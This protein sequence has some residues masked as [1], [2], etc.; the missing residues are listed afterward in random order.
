MKLE[1][2]CNG[3]EITLEVNGDERALDILRDRLGL[4]GTKEGCGKGEC[5]ACTVIVDGRTMN[6]CLL[7][8]AKLHGTRVTTIEGIHGRDGG[9]HPIQVAYLDKGAVQCGFCTPGMVL[10]TKTLLDEEPKPDRTR[11]SEALSGNF[12]RCTGY[13]KIVEAVE[14]AAELIER[15]GNE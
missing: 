6:S 15:D 13:T 14:H 2:I 3:K 4:T 5:G 10:S 9:L 7:T 12:C 8:A 1:F 11:I